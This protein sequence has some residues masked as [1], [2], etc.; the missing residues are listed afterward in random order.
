MVVEDLQ[1]VQDVCHLGHQLS[2]RGVAFLLRGGIL[3][4]EDWVEK[5][6]GIFF[7]LLIFCVLMLS[8][9]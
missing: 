7:Y 3:G 2:L 5:V 6:N 8:L 1:G 9:V 4:P